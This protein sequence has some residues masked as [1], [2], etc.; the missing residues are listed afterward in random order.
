[1]TRLFWQVTW[2]LKRLEFWGVRA[3]IQCVS[4]T[5]QCGATSPPERRTPDGVLTWAEEHLRQT[6][7]RR[8]DR[9]LFDT[10]QWDPPEDVDPR[11]IKGVTT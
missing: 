9:V 4:G 1:M 3:H 10:V 2:T 5:P 6:G 11:T 7:H 8:Y